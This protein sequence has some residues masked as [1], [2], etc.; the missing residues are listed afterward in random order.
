MGWLVTISRFAA[1]FEYIYPFKIRPSLFLLLCL[2]IEVQCDNPQQLLHGVIFIHQGV[3]CSLLMGM[4][5][6]LS[7]MEAWAIH[8]H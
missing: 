4:P 2:I 1:L 7:A 8:K 6:T 5:C 3:T